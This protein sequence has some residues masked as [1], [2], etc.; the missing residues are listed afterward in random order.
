VAIVESEKSALIASA[1]FPEL[2]WLAA[3]NINGLSIEKAKVL[4]G[5]N[6][7]LFPDLGAFSKWKEKA[8]M[9]NSLFPSPLGEGLGVR[10]STLLENEATDTDRINGLDIADFII[11]ELTSKKTSQE[12][13]KIFSQKLQSMIET[14]KGLLILIDGLELEEIQPYQ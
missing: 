9:L 10:C 4:K 14:N 7:T 6:V 8:Q 3:G 12:I 1:V 2:I 13:Q 11:A 5:R